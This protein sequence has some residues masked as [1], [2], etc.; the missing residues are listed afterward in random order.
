MTRNRRTCATVA[1]LAILCWSGPAHAHLMT[2]GVGPFYDGALHVLASVDQLLPL[3]ALGLLAGLRGKAAGRAVLFGLPP[4]LLAGAAAGR[5]GPPLPFIGVAS[6]VLLLALG[7]LVAADVRLSLRVVIVTAVGCGLLV[8]Y[9]NGVAMAEARLG[10]V[11]LFGIATAGFVAAAL[12]PAFV[13]SLRQAW[14]RI[15]VRVAGS[16]MVALGLLMVAWSV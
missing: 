4:A 5:W 10:V 6:T 2:T 1:A 16:W 8:G 7:G 14:M 3:L 13:V 12:V 11:S 15:A 9:A